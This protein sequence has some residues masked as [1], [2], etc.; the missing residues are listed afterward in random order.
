MNQTLGTNFTN[1][2]PNNIPRNDLVTAFLTGFA[3]VNQMAKVTASEM[4][5]LNTGIAAIPAASQSN[6]GVAGGDLAGFPN[7]RRPGDDTVDIALRVVMGALCYPAHHR[8]Q[9]R[10]PEAVHAG[11]C[12]A[13]PG[14][15]HRWRA[16]LGRRLRHH[17]PVSHDAA[18]RRGRLT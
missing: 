10:R 18:A 15:V 9:Q 4:T 6:F 2:A 14:A 16:G 5:R 1:I 7:G 12:A 11:Q 17:L 8:W 13:G 3:G